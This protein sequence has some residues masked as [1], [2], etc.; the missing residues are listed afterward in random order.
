MNEQFDD[1]FAGIFDDLNPNDF[2]G[3]TSA[4][5]RKETFQEFLEANLRAVRISYLAVDGNQLN[6]IAIL[7]AEDTEWT[8]APEDDESLGEYVDRLREEA[9]RL[10]AVRLFISRT[11]KVG[12]LPT[13]DLPD[14]GDLNTA[15][16]M[17]ENGELSDGAAFFGMER[18]GDVWE[19]VHGIMVA[20]ANRLGEAQYAPDD[21]S[22]DL[23]ARIL[24][25]SLP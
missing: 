25:Q 2:G 8:Y 24:D 4:P 6:P 20:F 12:V 15:T 17:M 5:A 9:K 11:T 19:R 1:E 23:F 14:A 21:Q 18:V 10:N 22:M 7:Q 16:E 3:V 13:G